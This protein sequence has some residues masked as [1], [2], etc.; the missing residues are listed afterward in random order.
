VLHRAHLPSVTVAYADGD[1]A[2]A[3]LS[4]ESCF[5]AEGDEPVAGFRVCEKPPGTVLVRGQGGGNFRGVALCLDGDDLVVTSQLEAGWHR[6]VSEW[7]FSA[8]GTLRPRIGFAAVRNPRTG[9]AHRHHAYW[10]LDFDIV[11]A[12]NN[13]V[14]E[15]NDPALGGLAR[16]HTIRYEV[17]RRRDERHNRHW[18]VRTVRSPHGYAVVPGPQDGEADEFGAGDVWVLAYHAEELDDGE[19]VTTHPAR[20]RAQLDGLVSGELVER[21]DLVLWYGVHVDGE[22]PDPVGPDLV[23]FNWKPPPER[24]AYEPLVPPPLKRPDD[25]DD[26]E[27]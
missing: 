3:W 26:D 9:V 7:R 17:S 20:A 11:A 4:Q 24:E 22:P 8:D 21:T 13:Q 16:W 5:E 15:H 27:E 18:R 1:A 2:R 23:P 19:G 12:G 25:E 14:Q 6:Y 10:R